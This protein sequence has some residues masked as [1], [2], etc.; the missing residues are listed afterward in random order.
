ML[1]NATV[2]GYKRR[3]GASPTGVPSFTPE[4]P[5]AVRC[6]LDTV[7]SSQKFT[8]GATIKDADQ[9][10]YL[11]YPAFGHVLA[12]DRITVQPDGE[13]EDALELEIVATKRHQ[14]AD[15]L[16]HWETYLKPAAV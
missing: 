8:I 10:A 7:S 3:T 2:T 14:L 6:F 4:S 13:G 9:V 15:S 12:G 5:L 16:S 1:K 11:P